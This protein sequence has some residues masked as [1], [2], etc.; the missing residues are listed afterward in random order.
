MEI[1]YKHFR[2]VYS[3]NTWALENAPLLPRNKLTVISA[4]EQSSGR[5]RSK[6]VWKSPPFKNLYAT[7]C[8][9]VPKEF[10]FIANLPQVL[11]IAAIEVFEKEGV[12][13]RVKWPND[14][15]AGQKKIGGIL[16]ETRDFG[17]ERFVAMGIGLNINMQM[18]DTLEAIKPITSLYLESNKEGD[19]AGILQSLSLNL[20]AKLELFLN[21]GFTPFLENFKSKMILNQ[22]IQFKDSSRNIHKGRGI[23]ILPDGSFKMLTESGEIKTF[24]SGELI[25]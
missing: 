4:D 16:T 23:D 21:E 5:G 1:V 10:S 20:S 14:L 24:H 2:V 8:L 3:T 18:D 13:T 19:V 11:A 6:N 9:F 25:E 22:E 15:Y 17:K 12:K 7:F